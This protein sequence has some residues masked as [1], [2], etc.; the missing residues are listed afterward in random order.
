MLDVIVLA[1]TLMAHRIVAIDDAISVEDCIAGLG[2]CW[3]P[4]YYRTTHEPVKE[5]IW[6]RRQVPND[7]LVFTYRNRREHSGQNYTYR[8]QR[9]Y[10]SLEIEHVKLNDSGLYHCSYTMENGDSGSN[11][12]LLRIHE[13]VIC[14][15]YTTCI[16]PCRDSISTTVRWISN[17]AVVYGQHQAVHYKDRVTLVANSTSLAISAVTEDDTNEYQ[18]NSFPIIVLYV[19]SK[20]YYNA[21]NH[22][23]LCLYLCNR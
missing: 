10:L 6:A 18:C 17:G 7:E 20:L 5:L 14:E 1:I 3:L 19:R 4:C 21:F 12:V 11:V 23:T 13:A 15:K 9:Q 8:L 22:G 2:N 16:L